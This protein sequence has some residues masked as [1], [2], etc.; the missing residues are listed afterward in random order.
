MILFSVGAKAERA[1]CRYLKRKGFRLLERNYRSGRHEIDLVMRDGD[2][3][4]FVEVKARSS[5]DYG[6]PGEFVTPR[7]QRFLYL[8]AQTY[9]KQ[10]RLIDEP[11]RFDV[12]EVY[13]PNQD[14]VHIADA[15]G[16]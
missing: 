16:T 14:I 15:F 10:N 8:A 5:A 1:A 7:K 4:V 12:I 11:A 9:L 6:T 3:V 13:L 2:T